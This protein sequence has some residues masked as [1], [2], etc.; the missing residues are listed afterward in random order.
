MK[1]SPQFSSPSRS[2]AVSHLFPKH[3]VPA[4]LPSQVPQAHCSSGP[5]HATLV[6]TQSSLGVTLCSS[7]VT[8]QKSQS[9]GHAANLRAPIFPSLFTP[10]SCSMWS[11]L[12]CLPSLF[13]TQRQSR[14]SVSNSYPCS[15]LV[16]QQ[17]LAHAKQFLCV[18]YK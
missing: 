17:R 10:A 13:Y 18:C 5:L 4:T 14:E 11:L 12:C 7:H 2:V 9:S 3:T 15:P 16:S 1:P 6:W 8:P